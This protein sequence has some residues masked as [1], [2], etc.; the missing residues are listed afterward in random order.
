MRPTLLALLALAPLTFVQPALAQEANDA[1]PKKKEKQAEEEAI[2]IQ[3]EAPDAEDKAA[4]PEEHQANKTPVNWVDVESTGTLSSAKDGA[5]GKTLWEG[6]PRSTVEHLLQKLPNTVHLRSALMLQ[7]RLLL[8]QT[9]AS[10]LKNDIGPLRGNDILIQRINKLMDMG[11]YD[12][13]WTLYTQKAEDPYDVSI[14]QLGMLLLVM[15]NDLA[16]ACLEEK[17]FSAKYPKDKF[18]GILDRA[19]AQTMGASKAPQFPDNTILQSVYNDSSYSV[20]ASNPQALIA[21]ND[22]ERALVLANGKIQYDGL[23]AATLRDTPSALVSLYLM[24]KNLP[25]SAKAMVKTETDSRGLSWHIASVAR[26]ELFVKAKNL[27]KDPED[28]WPVLESAMAAKTNPADIAPFVDWIAKAEPK[29][30]STETLTKV[31][32]AL[33]ASQKPLPNFWLDAA[34]KRAAEKPI[35]YIYL[36]AFNSLTPTPQAKVKSQDFFKSMESL[37]LAD[38]DQIIAIIESLDNEAD[39]LNNPLK[40]Y[41]KHSVLTLENNYVMP[42]I[43]LTELLETAPKEKQIGITVMAVLNALAA[44]PDNMYSGTVRKALYA[45]LNV[46]LIE[47]AKL[48]GS[49]TVA[50]VLNKY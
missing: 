42:S 26:D 39:F 6:Q 15:K 9:N 5:L 33:L 48:I 2:V 38:S 43:G 19:C 3:D 44:K 28:Q 27:S 12:D 29:E 46:G 11:L 14:A 34:Q 25:D 4:T 22:L 47:D 50:S 40:I 31:L 37:K 20:S 24:D 16:T 32:G 17:V 10:L 41:E 30:F 45:L 1:A 13:A 35:I 18:F 7:R 21:M 23:T 36:Q 49:E 8:S